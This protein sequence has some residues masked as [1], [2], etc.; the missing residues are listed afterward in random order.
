VSGLPA[1]ALVAAHEA[2]GQAAPRIIAFELGSMFAPFGIIYD[3]K[4][5]GGLLC[6][7]RCIGA[8][9]SS[10]SWLLEWQRMGLR[11]RFRPEFKVYTGNDPAIDMVMYGSDDLLGFSTLAPDFF[12]RRD[13]YWREGILRSM[14]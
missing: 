2:I 4:T 10:L 11:D 13:R 5:Y 7:P 9:H 12:A 6:I 14:N 1:D 8:K 3:L